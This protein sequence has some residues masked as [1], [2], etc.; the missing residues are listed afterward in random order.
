MIPKSTHRCLPRPESSQARSFRLGLHRR[1]QLEASFEHT[2]PLPKPTATTSRVLSA[3]V[4][5][6]RFRLFGW[7]L[8]AVTLLLHLPD[9]LPPTALRPSPEALLDLQRG[10]EVL[11]RCRARTL[12]LNRAVSVIELSRGVLPRA[13]LITTGD[14]AVGHRGS[15]P[16]TGINPR[17][18]PR[19]VGK[20]ERIIERVRVG[21]DRSPFAR[22]PPQVGRGLL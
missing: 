22:H 3:R 17:E 5:R 13:S 9:Q 20:L 21:R 6:G 4:I 1:S 10:V 12:E 18:E 11:T 16:F 15:S 7:L 2:R 19:G 8:R 14:T